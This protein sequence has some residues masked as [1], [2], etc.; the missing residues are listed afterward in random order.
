MKKSV[1]VLLIIIASLSSGILQAQSM[2]P[3]EQI[4]NEILITPF[5]DFYS[6]NNLFALSCGKGLTG[7]AGNNDIS[8]ISLNPASL[9]LQSKYQFK[10]EYSFRNSINWL[11]FSNYNDIYL[12]QN[13]PAGGFYF[14]YKINDKFQTGFSYRNDI[15]FQ[16]D[17]G[18]FDLFN[19]NGEKTGSYEYYQT[20][21]THSFSIPFVYKYKF[22]KA[23]IALNYILYRGYS[24]V[25]TGAYAVEKKYDFV[26]SFGKLVPDIGIQI[27]PIP[28][29]TI[30]LTYTQG[31]NK[32][33]EYDLHSVDTSL[34]NYISVTHFPSKFGFGVQLKLFEG[35]LNFEADYKFQN[36]S[37]NNMQKDRNDI[38]FG[39]DYAIDK[40]WN[41]RT[42]AFSL[43]D[44]RENDQY[45]TYED[46]IGSFNQY[47]L[48]FGAGY[49]LKEFDFN[50]ALMNSTIL[51]NSKV[52]HTK[53]NG[54]ISFS[55]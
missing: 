8:G 50:L 55:F 31:F 27:N 47:F 22:F 3:R 13:H 52:G 51:S 10:V 28:E 2:G 36:T 20:F 48:T 42:G 14:G 12:K 23:G 33:I 1:Y 4:S 49:K 32:N 24:P 30:G 35:R 41:I 54:S 38:N 18:M 29:L 5:W 21:N 19:S 7:I 39:I 46:S 53:L 16:M 15:N 34:A 44:N 9:D 26:T 17:L 11:P 25:F 6:Q 43:R 45:G 40:N 37:K